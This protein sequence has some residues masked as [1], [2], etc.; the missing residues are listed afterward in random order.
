VHFGTDHDHVAD[1]RPL[2]AALGLED[3]VTSI[4]ADE[5]S[6]PL[7]GHF[8]VYPL[9]PKVEEANHGAWR[10]WESFPSSTED[11][12]DK[13]A[14]RH[15]SDIVV[16][17]NHPTDNGMASMAGWSEGSVRSGDRWSE[18]FSAMEVLNAGSID[19][20][21][22]VWWDLTTRGV[23]STPV[24]VSDAHGPFSGRLGLSATYLGVGVDS[25]AALTDALLLDAV[26]SGRVVVTRGP[27]LSLS[28]DPG[29]TL[30]PDTTV[31]VE[32]LSPSWIVVDRLLLFRDGVEV[33]R[34]DG[35]TATFQLAP[36]ADAVYTVVAE[37]DTPMA[38]V[39][40]QR[41]W[42]MSGA[43]FVDVDGDGWTPPAPPLAVGER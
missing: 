22:D 34:V 24:G 8:N 9:E 16:A 19:D 18:R 41:P 5:V 42:A 15:G 33:S 21:L 4:V 39:D 7:R 13:L 32:A 31:E 2:V 29:S 38:P 37:G 1:Y 30:T 6:P 20:Y 23:I 12:F 28:V 43:L 36:E 3:A 10:W 27:F 26:Q 17:V 14:D 35:T 25:P 11:I 40:D